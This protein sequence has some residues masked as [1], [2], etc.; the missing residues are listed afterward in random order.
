MPRFRSNRWWTFILTIIALYV[1]S[2]SLAAKSSA[3]P[4]RENA[5]VPGGVDGTSGGGLPPPTGVGDPDQPVNTRLKY[6][7]RGSLGSG[8]TVLSSRPVGDRRVE[9]NV[10]MLRLSV[11]ERVL[12]SYWFRY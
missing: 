3:D 9:S 6:Y 11:M 2:L 1:V 4:I 10:W 7:Q 8:G 5:W 12:R